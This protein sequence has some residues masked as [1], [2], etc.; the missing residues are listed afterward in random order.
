MKSVDQGKKFFFCIGCQKSGTTILARVLDQHPDIAC[1]W[2]AYFLN[3][4]HEISV[5][6]PESKAW[7]KHGYDIE[8]VRR[9]HSD[10]SKINPLSL[11]SRFYRKL[12]RQF[13]FP[14]TPYKNAISEALTDFATRCNVNV[15]GD[16]WPWYLDFMEQMLTAFPD[17]RYIYTVRDP[18][19]IW[20]SAQ[21]FKGRERGDE[22]LSEMLAKDRIFERYRDKPNFLIVRYEDIITEPE[23]TGKKLYE[24]LDCDFKKE[25]LTYSKESDP[26]P[27]RWN[28][29]PE[30]GKQLDPNITTKWKK[31]MTSEQ[32]KHVSE[33]ASWFIEKYGYE[34]I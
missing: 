30:A 19:G 20:N 8:K 16:K 27:D 31:L 4:K 5:F 26:Y 21:R 32:I 9:W 3:P 28:W 7:G 15:V 33:T 17:A 1:L 24:F 18:R 2:E 14:I 34:K 10:V 25:Y 11:S 29:V 6:N 13:R 23:E 22:I 12:T